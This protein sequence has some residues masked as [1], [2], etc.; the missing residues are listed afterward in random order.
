MTSASP[1]PASAICEPYSHGHG[2]SVRG[3]ASERRRI[4]DKKIRKVASRRQ[5][6]ASLPEKPHASR[7]VAIDRGMLAIARWARRPRHQ[8][9]FDAM[10][11]WQPELSSSCRCRPCEPTIGPTKYDEG[12]KSC[13]R[14]F[15]ETAGS[16]RYSA[17]SR[18]PRMG[19]PAIR[20]IPWHVPGRERT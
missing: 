18:Q 16:V 9:G 2:H 4:I 1:W 5:F 14:M 13:W 3:R 15:S 7:M 6:S 12:S 19:S 11:R 17:G 10:N 8:L 20:R